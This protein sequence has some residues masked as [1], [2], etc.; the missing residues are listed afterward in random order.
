MSSLFQVFMFTFCIDFTCPAVMPTTSWAKSV[1]RHGDYL[2][3]THHIRINKKHWKGLSLQLK[4]ELFYHELGHAIRLKHSPSGIMKP[5]TYETNKTGSN[6]G[7][8]LREMQE[9]AGDRKNYQKY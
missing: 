6:W 9:F 4:R 3:K 8:L 7:E 1:P 5:L 2:P